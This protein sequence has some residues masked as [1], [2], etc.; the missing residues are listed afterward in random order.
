MPVQRLRSITFSIRHPMNDPNEISGTINPYAPVLE[1]ESIQ[2][3]DD[4]EVTR[5]KY[6]NHEASVR[7]IGSLYYLGSFF[8]VLFLAIPLMTLPQ[9][10]VG[11]IESALFLVLIPVYLCTAYGLRRLKPWSKISCTVVCVL[12]LLAIP[13]GTVINGYFLYLL[14]SEKGRIV[15]SPEYAKVRAATPHIKYRM[16]K[17]IWIPLLACLGLIGLVVIAALLSATWAN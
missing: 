2:N 14:H 5:R 11:S 15:F 3:F 9:G 12:G 16:S 4:V 17:W 10:N 6:L 1:I 13:V 7:S 8:L